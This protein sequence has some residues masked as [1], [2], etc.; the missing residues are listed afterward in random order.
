MPSLTL[1]TCPACS[2]SAGW[3]IASP[4][5]AEDRIRLTDRGLE[6][7]GLAAPADGL[8]PIGPPVVRC[9]GCAVVAASGPVRETVLAA[10]T[11][12]L[13]PEPRQN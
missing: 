10:A 13:R 2:S 6:E 8:E 3:L 12:A 4:V 11:A 7:H 5:A 9:G 1:P